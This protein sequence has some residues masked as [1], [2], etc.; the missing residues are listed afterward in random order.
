MSKISIELKWF[1]NK[2]LSNLNKFDALKDDPL[3]HIYRHACVLLGGNAF[4]LC[5]IMLYVD[6]R[7]TFI[8]LYYI[9]WLQDQA[10]ESG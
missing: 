6:I 8:G 2:K 5:I 4:P 7:D 1:K 10:R 3:V 9:L